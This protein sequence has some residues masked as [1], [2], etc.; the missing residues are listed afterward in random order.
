MFS[1][2]RSRRKEHVL[3]E[4]CRLYLLQLV[5]CHPESSYDALNEMYYGLKTVQACSLEACASACLDVLLKNQQ[6]FLNS[7]HNGLLVNTIAS[8]FQSIDEGQ[9]K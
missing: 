2:I 9:R 5:N 6:Y 8:I 1:S 3:Q 4:E 7:P